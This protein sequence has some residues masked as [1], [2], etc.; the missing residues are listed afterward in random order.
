[1]H[2]KSILTS[3]NRIPWGLLLTWVVLLGVVVY[4]VWD[5]QPAFHMGSPNA[6][7]GELTRNQVAFTDSLKKVQDVLVTYDQRFQQ[8]AD[9]D[10]EIVGSLKELDQRL[11]GGT[12]AWTL[13][14]IQQGLE[15]AVIQAELFKN[16]DL[17]VQFLNIVDRYLQQNNNP[18]F[19]P[20]RQAIAK[21]K[22]MLGTGVSTT[23]QNVVISLNAMVEVIPNL[24]Q[25]TLTFTPENTVSEPI[26][27]QNPMTW[28][29]YVHR[30][31][32]GIKTLVVVRHE[33]DHIQPYFTADE[34]A[35]VN[36]NIQ[37]MLLQAAYAAFR[38]DQHL[39]TNNV[40]MA[41]T[42]LNRYYDVDSPFGKSLI[43]TLTTLKQQTIAPPKTG[44]FA[45]IE[46]WN[47]LLATLKQNPPQANGVGVP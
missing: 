46:V 8:I 37:L 28:K 18:N 36:E 31:W 23:Q 30:L 33:V 19:L 15:Q 25:R 1:M 42:W 39:F 29:D 44:Q 13:L 47:Q 35:L 40:D 14:Q 11:N 2:D 17:A 4:L 41:V 27:T 3:V 32:S 5:K 43:D 16:P 24:K 10:T 45:S 22:Q 26:Q 12:N 38:G 34:A 7:V 20:L 9:H 21:D 6:S